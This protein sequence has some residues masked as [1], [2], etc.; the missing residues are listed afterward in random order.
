M[1]YVR[2]SSEP[3]STVKPMVEVTSGATHVRLEGSP[4]PRKGV[5]QQMMAPMG[6]SRK[7]SGCELRSTRACAGAGRG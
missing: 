3:Y 1:R 2:S 4:A 5:A 6:M 7:R